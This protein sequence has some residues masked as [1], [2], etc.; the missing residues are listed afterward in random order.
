MRAATRAFARPQLGNLS[1][2]VWVFACTRVRTDASCATHESPFWARRRASV[3]VYAHAH[4]AH[5]LTF[6]DAAFAEPAHPHTHPRQHRDEM[7][8]MQWHRLIP[9]S[10]YL[11]EF[12]QT[13]DRKRRMQQSGFRPQWSLSCLTFRTQFHADSR[14]AYAGGEGHLRLSGK[15]HQTLRLPEM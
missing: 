2:S 10:E 12:A 13:Y 9:S 1:P 3:L 11:R 6:T 14:R 4:A 7:R 8:K 5:R 15:L